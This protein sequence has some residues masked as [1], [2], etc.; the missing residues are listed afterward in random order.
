MF[1]F[2]CFNMEFHS[3]LEIETENNFDIKVI[4]YEF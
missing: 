2:L 1:L 3:Y 4:K